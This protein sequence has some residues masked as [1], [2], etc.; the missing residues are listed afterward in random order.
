[1]EVAAA[2]DR[3]PILISIPKFVA[4]TMAI[5]AEAI[6]RLRKQAAIL[7]RDRVREL[8][9]FRWVCDPSRAIAEAGFRPTFPLERGIPETARWYRGVGWL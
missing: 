8:C 7:N 3:R 9:A 1:M 5:T 6:A 4:R 2:M